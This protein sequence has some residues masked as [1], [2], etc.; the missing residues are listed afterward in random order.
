M[1]AKKIKDGT[2]YTYSGDLD[3]EVAKC[4]KEMAKIEKDFPMYEAIYEKAKRE[5]DAKVKRL[6]DLN[7][8]INLAK[9]EKGE[10][11]EN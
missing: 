8:F 5:R 4:K 6:H 2:R 1:R 11:N 10:N 9:K 3:V 7:S